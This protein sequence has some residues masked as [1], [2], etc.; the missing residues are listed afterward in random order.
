MS[1]T[2][3]ILATAF[4]WIGVGMA[5]ACLALIVAGNTEFLWQFEHT[6]FPLSWVFAGA[7][8]LAFAAFELSDDGS[9]VEAEAADR[10]AQ[11]SME[12]EAVEL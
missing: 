11:L 4:Y 3:R 12:W 5:L 2:Q 8:I 9:S 1:S 6:G 10:T 7:A